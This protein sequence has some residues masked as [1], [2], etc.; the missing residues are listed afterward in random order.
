MIPDMVFICCH[1]FWCNDL[2]Q[3]LF[4]AFTFVTLSGALRNFA[5]YSGNVVVLDFL[6]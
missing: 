5:T 4:S 6:Y 1:S 2:E 3:T